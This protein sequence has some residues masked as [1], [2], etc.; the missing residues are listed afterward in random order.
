MKQYLSLFV[1]WFLFVYG[2]G[3]LV[4]GVSSLLEDFSDTIIAANFILEIAAAAC[5]A[6]WWLIIIREWRKEG[7]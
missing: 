2:F 1:A 3:C 6:G 7:K 4:M 5:F